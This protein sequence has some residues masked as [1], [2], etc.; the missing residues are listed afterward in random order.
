MPYGFEIGDKVVYN[1]GRGTNLQAVVVGFEEPDER[2][3]KPPEAQPLV[4]LQGKTHPR[5]KKKG[6]KA[7]EP[8]VKTFPRQANRLAKLEG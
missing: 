3:P 2:S 6:D 7:P 8:E 1:H 5:P 4:I